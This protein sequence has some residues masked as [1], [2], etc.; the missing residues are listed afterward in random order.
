M[1]ELKAD[2]GLAGVGGINRRWIHRLHNLRKLGALDGHGQTF[3]P[4]QARRPCGFPLLGRREKKPS[5]KHRPQSAV[6]QGL[7][8]LRKPS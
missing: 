2:R 1:S 3:F 5:G 7:A 8:E 4:N 6:H